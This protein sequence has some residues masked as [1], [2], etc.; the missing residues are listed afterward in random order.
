MS[1][2]LTRNPVRGIGT[3]VSVFS[4]LHPKF[5]P[6][7]TAWATPNSGVVSYYLSK[8]YPVP[9]KGEENLN[10]L[11]LRKGCSGSVFHTQRVEDPSRGSR[12]S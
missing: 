12:G 3:S 7:H 1:T 8:G 2:P 4:L 11:K 9:Y 6:R 5:E 10:T